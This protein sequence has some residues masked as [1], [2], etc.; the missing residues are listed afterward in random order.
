MGI[1]KKKTK[2][3]FLHV[4]D[5]HLT[6]S[7]IVE[8]VDKK[9]KVGGMLHPLRT[10][11]LRNTLRSLAVKLKGEGTELAAVLFSGDGTFQ[12][13]PDG[14]A[15]LRDM[16]V[17]ELATVGIT[18]ANLVATPG[19]HDVIA[20]SE[21]SKQSRYDL[22][23]KAWINSDPVVV[24][25]LDGVHKLD[26]LKFS[27]HVLKDPEGAWAIFPIN[28]SN[29]SQL[30]IPDEGNEKVANLRKYVNGSTSTDLIKALEKLCTYD[31]ARVSPDQLRA[32]KEMVKQ[33]GEVR[34]RIA[35][36][37]HHLL[38]VD[39]REEFKPFSDV[40]NLGEIR[41]VLRELDF[42]IVVHGHKHVTA[43]YY[44]HIYPDNSE[45]VAAHRILTLSGGSF[46]PTGQRPDNPLRLI[47]I[48]GVPNAPVCKIRSVCSDSAGRPL[49]ITDSSNYRLWEDDQTASGPTTIYGKSIDD[50]YA[51]AIQSVKQAPD[52]TIICTV[53]F[54]QQE[55][56]PFPLAYPYG[57][58][59]EERRAWFE[60]TVRWWQLPASRIEARIP[61]IHGSRLKRYGGG[62]DQI[63]RVVELLQSQKETS[64]EKA[65]SK[66]I[67][68][69]VDPVRDF[70][71]GKPFASFC[72]VQFCLRP[73]NRL[74]CIGY[75][76]AQEFNYW[77]PVNVAELRHLQLEVAGRVPVSPGKI[78]TIT[79]YPRLSLGIRH[80][81]KV[82]VPL[83]DQWVDNHPVRIAQ[84]AL[85]LTN[86]TCKSIND[87][88]RFWKR[89]LDD[90][91]HAA[92]A[93][94]HED[95]V[96]VSIEGLELLRDWLDAA[97]ESLGVI[98]LID[99]LLTANRAH[100]GS[101]HM[102]EDFE[103]WGKQVSPIL[104]SLR[105]FPSS[106]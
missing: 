2:L 45:S 91:T 52:R 80:P 47:E 85:A 44:D 101:R 10:D 95:G 28:T 16:L 53:D 60:E 54:Q 39:G 41:Q 100:M 58:N 67:A 92:T 38:P 79:P 55:E 96:Q 102:K 64:S 48:D 77:W 87:G 37:H 65:T 4:T 104:G 6:K 23:L 81:S 90:L 99:D 13:D 70:I 106:Q 11:M 72:F 86:S 71:K 34:L 3:T 26:E 62:T 29:W 43:A 17:S 84:I 73:D 8:T 75:Y 93:D 1:T 88:I 15:L 51:R 32:L 68:F 24:P 59:E 12:G 56:T 5:C 27:E 7:A 46:G 25:F 63:T 74:D 14:Q 21:P 69:V 98:K 35:V 83:I 31:I 40:T 82:A 42:H 33:A 36:L 105:N 61:Y 76:R 66:A 18:K 50:V 94:Y 103:R 97:G 78:T 89:C 20:R 9:V 57:E 19:N 30:S 49:K 22:F